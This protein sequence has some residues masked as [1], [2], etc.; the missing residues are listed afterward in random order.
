MPISGSAQAK[1]LTI[2]YSAIYPPPKIG[3]PDAITGDFAP[4]K[5]GSGLS[6]AG[7]TG[8]GVRGYAP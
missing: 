7:G 8:A 4:A 1:S 6:D 5:S 3:A 2:R